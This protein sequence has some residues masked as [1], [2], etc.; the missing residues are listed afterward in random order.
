MCS[1]VQKMRFLS[2]NAKKNAKIENVLHK[3]VEK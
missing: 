3:V 1:D 2:E